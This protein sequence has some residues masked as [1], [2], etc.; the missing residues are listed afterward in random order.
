[1]RT[2]FIAP[3]FIALNAAFSPPR[4]CKHYLTLDGSNLELGIWLASGLHR[5]HVDECELQN[6]EKLVADI[7]AL[8]AGDDPNVIDSCEAGTD[9]QKSDLT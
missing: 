1:M 9:Q 3:A 8:L 2:S 7:R 5:F 4:C 6:P